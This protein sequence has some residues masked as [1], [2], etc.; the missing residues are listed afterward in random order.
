MLEGRCARGKKM[1]KFMVDKITT[2]SEFI[3]RL[4]DIES[5][6][7]KYNELF[8]RGHEDVSYLLEPSLYRSDRLINNEYKLFKEIILENP[9]DFNEDSTTLEKLVRMQHFGL[10]TRILDLTRNP[11]VAL[12]FAC[13]NQNGLVN[14]NK[15]GEVVVLTIPDKEIK[16]YDSDSISIL[17]NLCKL[18]PSEKIF[19]TSLEKTKFNKEANVYKLLHAIREE[20]SYFTNVMVPEDINSI[21]CVKAKKNNRRILIQDGLFLIFGIGKN[22]IRIKINQDWILFKK[23]EEKIIIDK[24]SKRKII[25]ELETISITRKTLF[26][27][28]ESSAKMLKKKYS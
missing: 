16:Y 11:L 25:K 13:S 14:K 8:Y 23:E 27:D 20:K 9:N 24:N 19:N 12:Y 5:K 22:E 18:K 28:I 3:V 4:E 21:F 7:I 17:S 15:D 26:P 10:P 2:L 6:K 1:E